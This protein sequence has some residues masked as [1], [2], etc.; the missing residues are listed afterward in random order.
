VLPL[1]F[2]LVAW[3]ICKDLQAG[4]RVA[5]D[6]RHAQAEARLARMRRA[7]ESR[8]DSGYAHGGV[9]DDPDS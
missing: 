2:G 1:V 3:W 8:V 6:R 7:Q 9:W 5:A 4:E